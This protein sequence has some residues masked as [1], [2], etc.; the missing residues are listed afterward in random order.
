MFKL[1]GSWRQIFALTVNM[2][3]SN[4]CISEGHPLLRGLLLNNVPSGSFSHDLYESYFNRIF[5]RNAEAI[6]TLNVLMS[7]TNNVVYDNRNLDYQ[8]AG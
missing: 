7:I 4:N 6:K 2:I 3:S 5:R 8:N 1:V